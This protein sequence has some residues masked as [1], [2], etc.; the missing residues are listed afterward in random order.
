MSRPNFRA[1]ALKRLEIEGQA[2]YLRR[3]SVAESQ[4][5]AEAIKADSI[6]GAALAVFS[7]AVCDQGKAIYESPEQVLEELSIA[8]LMQIMPEI[9]A[10][11]QGEAKPA[12]N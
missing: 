12:T 5:I 4:R 1:S 9:T 6:R 10:H 3:L 8:I 7:A 11:T 2:L